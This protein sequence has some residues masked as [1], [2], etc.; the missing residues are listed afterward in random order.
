M[1]MGILD[2]VR[3]M[4]GGED[5]TFE[6]RCDRCETRFESSEADMSAVSCPEC[7]STKIRSVAA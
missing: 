6:Y 1:D 2:T 7:G 4:L 5:R 3:S